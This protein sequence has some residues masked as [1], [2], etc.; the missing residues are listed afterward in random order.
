M[1]ARTMIVTATAAA[2]A[3]VA[4]MGTMATASAAP[5]AHLRPAAAADAGISFSMVRSSAAAN[6]NC[7]SGVT[8]NVKIVSHELNET[9]TVNAA[10]LPANTDFDLFITQ[11][12][13]APFGLSWYQSDLQSD[14]HGNAA[15]TVVGRF[16]I[17]TF[18]V[19][20]GTGAA[21]T[22]HSSKDAASNPAFAPIHTFHVGFWFNSP[23]DAVK[24]GCP[25]TVTPFNGDHT[26]GIQAMS[27]RNF[28]DLKGPLSALKS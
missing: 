7:L 21:P 16:N 24:A 26:A 3:A 11:L 14:S 13:N 28:A 4:T 1:N 22:P 5:S 27:T 8:A 6:A 25:G 10:G 18:A 2:A 17:E 19:A 15:V 9:M 20:P 12:P 23:A